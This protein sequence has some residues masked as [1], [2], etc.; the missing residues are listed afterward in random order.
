[1]ICALLAIVCF[2]WLYIII[3]V[4]VKINL[5]SPV[6][7]KQMRPGL[8]EKIFPLYKF[9]TMTDERD[10][11]GELLP[12]EV[13]LTKFGKWLRS[14]SLDELPEAFNILNGTMSVIGPRP[15]L[16]RDM[17]F[18]TSEQRQRHSVKPGLSGLAQVNGRNGISWEEKLNWDLKYIGKITFLGDLKIIGQTVM[19]AFVKQEGVMREGT[20]S[21]MDFG[22]YLLSKGAVDQEEYDER[23][24]EAKKLL[25][26]RK[27][28]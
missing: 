22:D 2:C 25:A 7:F 11:N 19:K 3:A 15:Q 24:T 13:R 6:I 5:G 16:V 21:D 4:L 14:T 8:N 10:A 23:Q 1:M 18:M 20:V 27:I 9:R 12:D 26:M 17:V 28:G